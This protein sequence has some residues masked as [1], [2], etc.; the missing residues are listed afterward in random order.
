MNI[1]LTPRLA[2]ELDTVLEAGTTTTM[3]LNLWGRVAHYMGGTITA[4]RWRTV[5]T[6]DVLTITI[7]DGDDPY[8]FVLGVVD[9]TDTE[10]FEATEAPFAALLGVT[11][12]TTFKATSRHD[13]HGDAMTAETLNTLRTG[14]GLSVTELADLLA[15][16]GRTV[17]SWQSGRDPIGA[18]VTV[19]MNEL[20][21]RFWAEVH[22]HIEAFTTRT[23]VPPVI[24]V[25]H[26]DDTMPAGW[27][28]AVAFQVRQQV[29]RLIIV[30]DSADDD[31][32]PAQIP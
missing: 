17:R 29:P 16:N 9:P 28:R 15:V 3:L 27:Q 21:E 2:D 4:F 26:G 6:Q 19:R 7:D 10:S 24:L 12:D 5:W 13:L 14:M 23:R 20:E 18:W 32:T 22:H 31:N 11:A 1:P 30:A 25:E 8:E